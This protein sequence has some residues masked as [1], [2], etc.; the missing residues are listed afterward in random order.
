MFHNQ[1]KFGKIGPQQWALYSWSRNSFSSLTRLALQRADWQTTRLTPSASLETILSLAKIGQL[2]RAIYSWGRKS[3]SSLSG[4][5]R[6]RGESNT[7]R[8]TPSMCSATLV[9]LVETGQQQR[10]HYARG[11]NSFCSLPRLSRCKVNEIPHVALPLHAPQA[12]QVWSKSG[13]YKGTFILEAVTVFGLYLAS[14]YCGVKK[15][16]VALHLHAPQKMYG[17]IRAGT[18]STLLRNSEQF[19][20]S[21]T[22]APRARWLKHHIWHLHVLRNH[23]KFGRSRAVTKGTLLFRPKQF[24]VPI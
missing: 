22:P 11:R 23:C 9:S 19:F 15:L 24:F 20:V 13:S 12:W 21:K 17:R 16:Y 10:A 1:C 3:F 6:Q 7:T 14:Q 4:L 18:M 8:R 5:V 2:Q